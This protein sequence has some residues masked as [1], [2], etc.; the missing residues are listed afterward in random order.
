[1]NFVKRFSF[2]TVLALS[3]LAYIRVGLAD[4]GVGCWSVPVW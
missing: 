2:F 4:C 3:Q 1:M